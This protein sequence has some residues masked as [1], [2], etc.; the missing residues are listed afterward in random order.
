MKVA[1]RRKYRQKNAVS[2]F[3][4]ERYEEMR[5]VNSCIRDLD[6]IRISWIRKLCAACSRGRGRHVGSKIKRAVS[7]RKNDRKQKKICITVE[8]FETEDC[9]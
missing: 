6:A 3:T 1:G 5:I 9:Q 4:N 2:M 7:M 8:E